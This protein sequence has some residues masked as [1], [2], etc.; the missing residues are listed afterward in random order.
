M[1]QIFDENP[2]VKLAI[3]RLI[4]RDE[5]MVRG[6]AEEVSE[7]GGKLGPSKVYKCKKGG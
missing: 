5:R 2:V 3:R 4:L 1:E 6:P 7:V